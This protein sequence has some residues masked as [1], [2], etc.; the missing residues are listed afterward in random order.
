MEDILFYSLS[1]IEYALTE[2]AN[3]IGQPRS[4]LAPQSSSLSMIPADWPNL[5][6]SKTTSPLFVS[7]LNEWRTLA[8]HV[9]YISSWFSANRLANKRIVHQTSHL[10]YRGCSS[11]EHTAPDS[12]NCRRRKCPNRLFDRS[13]IRM[14]DDVPAKFCCP[15]SAQWHRNRR[16]LF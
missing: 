8:N 4:S 3:E 7:P 9:Q 2:L 1:N 5:L 16:H 10:L 13:D 12:G 15:Y 14:K 11:T 6:A